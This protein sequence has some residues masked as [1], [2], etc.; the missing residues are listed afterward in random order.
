[1]R[2]LGTPVYSSALFRSA[3]NQFP[4]HIEFCVVRLGGNPI[5]AAMLSHGLGIT[6]VPSA[7][8]LRE[9][10]STCANMLMYW[11]L[12][13][14]A[15]ERHQTIFDFGRSSL[16]SSTYRFKQQWG[17]MPGISVWNYHVRQGDHS[18]MRPAHP[19]NQRLIK[20][21]RRLPLPLSRLLGPNIV[22]AI[23]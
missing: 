18:R 23:P 11:K 8:S 4:D 16:D 19:R 20:I 21:W 10:N 15:I 9:Y 7:S 22:R 2:D 5:A 17:A 13:V 12:L 14:R 3:L 1:M 6:E